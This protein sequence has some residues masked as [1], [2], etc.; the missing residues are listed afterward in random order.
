MA[1]R[2]IKNRD[3]NMDLLRVVAAFMVIVIH[4]SAYNFGDTPSKST[5]WLSYNFFDSIV[6]S[7]VPIF[8]M[9]SGACF[10][11]KKTQ[12][13]VKKIY[14]KN[15][16][17]LLI[18]FIF[19]SIVYALFSLYTGRI[20]KGQVIDSIITGHFH[21]WYLPTII[22]IYIISPLIY[23]F[24]KNA[25]VNIYKYFIVL[26]L[27]ASFLKTISYLE[28]LPF[29]NHINLLLRNL[30]IDIIFGYYSYFILGYIL[31]NYNILEKYSK[32]IYILGI[33]SI[34]LCFVGTYFLSLYSGY[35]NP[36]L[37]REFSIFTLFESIGVFLFFKNKVTISDCAI[38]KKITNVAN[39][40]LGTYVIHLL[41]MYM[42]FDLNIINIRSFN[43]FLSVPVIS[44]ITFILSLTLV[45]V[46]KKVK[47][48]GNWVF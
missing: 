37:M 3:Y 40:T 1:N 19:W 18:V 38:G 16:L 45:Y 43:T 29:Y 41:V 15:I 48:I 12:G 9:I 39:C 30:P 47:F 24:V 6:R 27:C 32:T 42:L 31:Y 44:V 33:I 22:G 10:L 7:A 13:N 28:F 17:K 8:L 20:T 23:R 36:N 4:V 5:E 34:I 11:N 26:L 21:L 14:S 35:N 2:N 25:S 46:V